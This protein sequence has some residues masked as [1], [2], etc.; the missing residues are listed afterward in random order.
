MAMTAAAFFVWTDSIIGYGGSLREGR[1][2]QGWYMT[3]HSNGLYCITL[4]L[5]GT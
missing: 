2:N 4:G 3:P 5:S 1:G